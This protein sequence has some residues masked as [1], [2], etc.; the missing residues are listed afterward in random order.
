MSET[1]TSAA[2]EASAQTTSNENGQDQANTQESEQKAQAAIE[3]RKYKY[4]VDGQDIEEEYSDDEIKSQLAL[5]KAS[6]KRFQ[7]AAA[8]KKQSEQFLKMLRENPLE[9]LNNEQVMGQKKF[10]ELA[11]EYLAKE[12]Q[13]QMLSPEEKRQ[14]DMQRELEKYKESERKQK[15]SQEAQQMEQLQQHY[16]QDF[17]AKILTGLNS[18]SLPKTPTTVKRMAEL[19]QKSL[20]NGYDLAPEQ[21][22][23]LVKKE[24]VRDIQELFGATEGDILLNLLGDGVSNKIRQSDLKRL[25][26]NNPFNR[27]Q[28]QNSNFI[29]DSKPSE[30]MSKDDWKE[31]LDKKIR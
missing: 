8:T 12:L 5:A 11:E 1:A 21:L 18:Q 16:A 24:Y 28:N 2:P 20:Q 23:E 26:A 6:T 31:M 17:E 30:K 9:I 19:M 4:K 3:K 25:K 27:Q 13:E 15:E 14:R 29:Q 22:A 7:E 10:R